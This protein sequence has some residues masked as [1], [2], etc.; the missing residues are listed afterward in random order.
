MPAIYLLRTFGSTLPCRA[1][2]TA[3]FDLREGAPT[4]KV[5]RP[6]HVHGELGGDVEVLVAPLACHHAREEIEGAIERD[7]GLT[8]H[9]AR[10]RLRLRLRESAR[11]CFMR[12]ARRNG[13]VRGSADQNEQQQKPHA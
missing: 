5:G 6:W 10:V 8:L 2:N 11:R 1:V 9:L 7:A 4:L 3:A 13:E 12:F